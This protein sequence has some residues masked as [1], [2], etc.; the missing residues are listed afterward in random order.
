MHPAK[1][2]LISDCYKPFGNKQEFM[3]EGKN[4][5]IVEVVYAQAVIYVSTHLPRK[6]VKWKGIPCLI[7]I[8]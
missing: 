8:H 3:F 6:L 1:K 7:I 2:K 5:S 4:I